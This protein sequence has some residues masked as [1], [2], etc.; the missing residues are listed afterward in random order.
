MNTFESNFHN[1]GLYLESKYLESFTKLKNFLESSNTDNYF[2]N[3]I[4]IA[5]ENEE[6]MAY[7][8]LDAKNRYP[9]DKLSALLPAGANVDEISNLG[10][11]FSIDGCNLEIFHDDSL[12][13]VCYFEITNKNQPDNTIINIDDIL[14][15]SKIDIENLCK[16]VENDEFKKYMILDNMTR[17]NDLHPQNI[18]S[19]TDSIKDDEVKLD[20][21]SEYLN[22]NDKESL[23]IA[24]NVVKNLSSD[25]HKIDFLEN[26]NLSQTLK[27]RDMVNIIS[28]LSNDM[29]KI[30]LLNNEQFGGHIEEKDKLNIISSFKSDQHKLDFLNKFDLTEEINYPSIIDIIL[31]IENDNIKKDIIFNE[32][33][34]GILL[35]KF[36]GS[37]DNKK[38]IIK[39][40]ESI[41]D[42]KIKLQIIEDENIMPMVDSFNSLGDL[43]ASIKSDDV[44]MGCLAN[45][46]LLEHIQKDKLSFVIKSFNNE[47]IKKEL[48]CSPLLHNLSD[49]S[50]SSILNTITDDNIIIDVLENIKIN[51]GIDSNKLCKIICNI[52]NDKLKTTI[53]TDTHILDNSAEHITNL[54][55]SIDDQSLM[56]TLLL[57]PNIVK[58]LDNNGLFIILYNIR[59]D[60]IINK[61]ITNNDVY[62]ILESSEIAKVISKLSDDRFITQILENSEISQKIKYEDMSYIFSSLKSDNTRLQLL[63][64]LDITLLDSQTIS[65]IV[66][67]FRDEKYKEQL[68]SDHK[69][70]SVLSAEDLTKSLL[71]ISNDE[72]KSR[73]IINEKICQQLENTHNVFI[74]VNSIKDDACKVKFF[75]SK[76]A[77]EFV[78]HPELITLISNL[79][80]DLLKIDYLHMAK[81]DSDFTL[82]F[83]SI[84]NFSFKNTITKMKNLN[85]DDEIKKDYIMSFLKN[86]GMEIS[87]I[88]RNDDNFF[89][90]ID[91]ISDYTKRLENSNSQEVRTLK[92]LFMQHML[93]HPTPYEYL[94]KVEKIFLKNH[95]PYFAKAFSIFRIMNQDLLE[96]CERFATISP[97]LKQ[98]KSAFRRELILFSDLVKVSFGSNNRNVKN[99]LKDLKIGY[100][101]FSKALDDDKLIV[102]FSENEKSIYNEY[103]KKL[104]V[105]H[106]NMQENSA[107]ISFDGKS[108]SEIL[109]LFRNENINKSELN[110]IIFKKF[111]HFSGFKNIEDVEYYMTE[112]IK[113]RENKNIEASSKEFSLKSGDLIK[114]A[115]HICYLNNILQNGS[116]SKEF[117]GTA[118]NSDYTPLDTD[119]S[120]ILEDI[121]DPSEIKRYPADS[122]GNVLFV[123]KNDGRFLL[124]RDGEQ[125]Y[126]V[127]NSD[128]NKTELFCT[129]VT[130]K[131]HYGIRTG[132]A[133][134]EIDFMIAKWDEDKVKLEIVKNGF[135]IPV[136]D[137]NMNLIF[138][139]NDYLELKSRLNGL[140]YYESSNYDISNDLYFN[141]I[142]D[143]KEE[144]SKEIDKI[145]NI[146]NTLNNSIN[147]VLE[148]FNITKG[149]LGDISSGTYQIFD[150]GST[151]R[152]TN[153]PGDSDFDLILKLDNLVMNDTESL[154]AIKNK[155]KN[156]FTE[157][158]EM[159]ITGNGDFRIKGANLAELDEKI[160][161][162]ISFSIK[163]DKLNYTTEQCLEDRYNTIKKEHPDKY[164]DVLAN[165]VY[166]KKFLKEK[167]IYKSA[168][169]AVPDGGMG[170]VGVENW[171][172]QNGGSFK[173]AVES[174]M[175]VANGKTFEE[176]CRHYS[177]W[178]FGENHMSI[179]KGTYLHDNFVANN[180]SE[181]GYDKMKKEFSKLLNLE[182][183]NTT[184]LENTNSDEM[185]R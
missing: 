63:E 92:N 89:D 86:K 48:L 167:H 120:M 5:G 78:T 164:I 30:N 72:I 124:T 136:V 137:I 81:D 180:M 32:K 111:F 104:E 144:I 134:S 122:Y 45:S 25:Q 125:E 37:F 177:V 88:D 155:L 157:V 42:D 114:G 171:I 84:T 15:N 57:D 13:D 38:N 173:N 76:E 55:L 40:I 181:A 168:R 87:I 22:K 69:Y 60:D 174:F 41:N 175:S 65:N 29:N 93:T 21:I 128:L 107:I 135:Y 83:E 110:D 108:A 162:D 130:G 163:T 149:S 82:I 52:S 47:L 160:D 9:A 153:V 179:Q 123:L 94:D 169:S 31:S 99:Y 131:S 91:K 50:I 146:K 36:S 33:F 165:I 133:S 139:Y 105:I 18:Y 116:V 49:K 170:G 71:L 118:L 1:Y 54:F 101:L 147:N 35:E 20:I 166:A 68:L 151:N 17:F 11:I 142:E 4:G 159:V 59:S 6:L 178:D 61:L 132:F 158:D 2:S 80:D 106:N 44:K 73:F 70:L 64:G 27:N 67:S 152:C 117:F 85:V 172:L 24:L 115:G 138:S 119:L 126:Q 26:N 77:T 97:A 14:G 156:I 141:S 7:A 109:D 184:M 66:N 53:L 127:K 112:K 182:H 8:L 74:V 98:S 43:V 19:I 62:N 56:E 113:E 3:L 79:S 103:V 46:T 185:V 51:A 121:K 161:V 100:D 148:E 129:G 150:T 102:S 140:S 10:K 90:V 16:S 12:K 96:K 95:L 58:S 143:E 183:E 23:H 28:S 176:F 75:N 34:S 39:V 154:T 145:T